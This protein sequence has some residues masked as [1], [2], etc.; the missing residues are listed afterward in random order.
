MSVKWLICR[1]I[2]L[3]A[4]EASL[5]LTDDAQTLTVLGRDAKTWLNTKALFFSDEYTFIIICYQMAFNANCAAKLFMN[6]LN[7]I[8]FTKQTIYII[9]LKSYR[10]WAMK[11]FCS[12][13]NFAGTACGLSVKQTRQRGHATEFTYFKLRSTEF[14]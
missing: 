13:N 3:Q 4:A 10:R 7:Y 9:I 12:V 11:L 2:T 6:R 5:S 1:E 8:R 14:W